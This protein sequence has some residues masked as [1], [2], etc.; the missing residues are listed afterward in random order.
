[1]Y[2]HHSNLSCTVVFS[3]NPSRKEIFLTYDCDDL[4]YTNI[5]QLLKTLEDNMV[6]A[7]FFLT[8]LWTEKNPL[9]AKMIASKG[10]LI[11]NHSYNHPH[12]SEMSAYDIR[13]NI[14]KAESV[15]KGITGVAT[16]PFFRAPFGEFNEFVL[17]GAALAGYPY[18]IHWSIDTS[19]WKQ[20]T[21]KAI[22]ERIFR[23]LS[24]N[25]IILMHGH[26]RST[27]SATD[28][29]IRTLK[30]YGYNFVTVDKCIQAIY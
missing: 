11:G 9:L 5:L 12:L 8:G 30:P 23:N 18:C 2:S 27:V 25:E 14:L 22:V 24:Q 17:K 3:G 10:H 21:D 28:F 6:T 20:P 29:T 19:D 1:M 15:I 13:D 7:T 16:R 4:E 26:G